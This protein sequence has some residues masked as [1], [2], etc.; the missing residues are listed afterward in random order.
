MGAVSFGD[1]P[2]I[3]ATSSFAS[4]S[5]EQLQ[6][7]F[8]ALVPNIE[9]HAR[10]A[11]G[12]Y[13]CANQKDDKVAEAVALAWKWFVRLHKRG[14]NASTFPVVFA[15]LVARAVAGG[16]RIAGGEPAGDVLSK[17]AQRKHGFSVKGL[18]DSD[19][20]P[21]HQLFSDPHAQKTIDTLEERLADNTQT[22]VP[23]QAAFRIDF[24]AWMRT[25]SA[26]ERLLAQAMMREEG[27]NDLS[28]KFGVSA[29]RISQIR[30]ELR[31]EWAR[32]C[33]DEG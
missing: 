32:F 25:L 11:F 30:S 2:M 31:T 6:V 12:Y 26:R 20:I 29:G 9:K 17:L 7:A 16:R 28:R 8:L 18:S 24:P 22:P 19:G 5:P 13:K 1:H 14:K 27:T 15:S 21:I 33:G 23:D 4:R 3:A 10:N